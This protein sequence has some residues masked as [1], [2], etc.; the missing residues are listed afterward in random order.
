[1]I[2]IVLSLKEVEPEKAVFLLTNPTERG[3]MEYALEQGKLYEAGNGVSPR[4]APCN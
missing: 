3:H 4:L 1:M 2:L